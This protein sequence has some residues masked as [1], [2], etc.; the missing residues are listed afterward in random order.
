MRNRLNVHWHGK[1]TTARFSCRIWRMARMALQ[2]SDD[3]LIDLVN[4]DLEK[5]NRDSNF[6]DH[7]AS[8]AVHAYLCT[9]IELALFHVGFNPDSSRAPGT[10]NTPNSEA[11]EA[12]PSTG[13]N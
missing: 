11:A 1:R 13:R 10:G 6:S 7:T 3:E 12:R 9:E 4:K 5:T 2:C 8:D